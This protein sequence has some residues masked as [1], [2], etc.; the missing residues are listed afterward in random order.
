MLPRTWQ[1]DCIENERKVVHETLAYH[2]TCYLFLLIF[3]GLVR[4]FRRGDNTKVDDFIWSEFFI[5]ILLLFIIFI[6]FFYPCIALAESR[7]IDGRPWE[8]PSTWIS[9]GPPWRSLLGYTVKKL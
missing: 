2:S 1:K 9:P 8:R 3:A 5:I 7:R 6:I 4:M